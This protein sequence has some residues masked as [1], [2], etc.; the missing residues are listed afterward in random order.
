VTGAVR[1][2]LARLVV[3]AGVLAAHDDTRH[4]VKNKTIFGQTG[5]YAWQDV[6]DLCV[7][8]PSHAPFLC[9]KLWD[10]L[11]GGTPDQATVTRLRRGVRLEDGKTAPAHVRILESLPTKAWLEIGVREGRKHLVRRMC[12][13]VGHAVDKL[14]RVRLGPLGLGDLPAGAW[15]DVTPREI[16]AL[17]VAAGLSARRR[18]RRRVAAGAGQGPRVRGRR[19]RKPRSR[20]GSPSEGAVRSE[21][22]ARSAEGPRRPRRGSRPPRS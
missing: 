2:Y 5:N 12:E 14:A 17:R 1:P 16:G 20:P 19:P 6:L 10:Y 18:G 4:D 3:L 8:H 13:A 7:A 21:G 15:R 9:S 22:S 11:V